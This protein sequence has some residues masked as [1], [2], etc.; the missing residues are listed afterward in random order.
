MTF[1]MKARKVYPE[2]LVL[3]SIPY[4]WI[5]TI[6]GSLKQMEWILPAFTGSREEFLLRHDRVMGELAKE[7]QNP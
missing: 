6:T 7:F 3:I 5:Q 1:G 2:G 4:N